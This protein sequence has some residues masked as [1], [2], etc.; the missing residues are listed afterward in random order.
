MEKKTIK[1]NKFLYPIPD[2]LLEEIRQRLGRDK[3]AEAHVR[4]I[5]K[6]LVEHKFVF[7]HDQDAVQE[8]AEFICLVFV[9]SK[10]KPEGRKHAVDSDKADR[11]C[12]SQ[13]RKNEFM[14]DDYSNPATFLNC[15]S[16]HDNRYLYSTD[17]SLRL[18]QN[19]VG[20]QMWPQHMCVL[21]ENRTFRHV[22]CTPEH[23]VFTEEVLYLLSQDEVAQFFATDK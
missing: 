12:V 11:I 17:E 20:V 13:F 19:K 16:Y 7:V 1:D 18:S 15:H 4:L 22:D 8:T 10:G 14:S 9:E 3:A 2:F 21:F 5:F 23:K 6:R